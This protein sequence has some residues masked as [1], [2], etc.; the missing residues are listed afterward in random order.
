M[1]TTSY[2]WND[3]AHND[4]PIVLDK[5]LCVLIEQSPDG[6]KQ[7][8]GILWDEEALRRLL[9]LASDGQDA[10]EAVTTLKRIQDIFEEER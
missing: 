3:W 8:I 4:L 2:L 5:S 7:V 1:T 6:E 9:R 10:A